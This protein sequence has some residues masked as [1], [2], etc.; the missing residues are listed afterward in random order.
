MPRRADASQIAVRELAAR[1]LTSAK[2]LGEVV[3][4]L[5]TRLETIDRSLAA[6]VKASQ[7]EIG[8]LARRLEGLE[9]RLDRLVSGDL[10]WLE[11]DVA[12]IKR[13]VGLR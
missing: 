3:R 13:A 11:R 2:G 7:E 9:E 10:V 4:E 12:E 5:A 8:A 1:A 6:F